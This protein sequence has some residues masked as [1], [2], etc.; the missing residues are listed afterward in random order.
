MRKTTLPAASSSIVHWRICSATAYST[1][2]G[3]C[4][5]SRTTAGASGEAWTTLRFPAH[6]AVEVTSPND[7]AY[8]VEDKVAEY[9]GARVPLVWVLDP[10]TWTVR[11]YRPA[12]SPLGSGLV[13]RETDTL[14]GEDVLPGFSC[15][16]REI[17]QD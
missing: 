16:V 15:P 11:V 12:N 17:F 13:L 2:E 14:S 6:L 9:L 10:P 8:E 1:S 4:A 3:R 7:L 5:Q